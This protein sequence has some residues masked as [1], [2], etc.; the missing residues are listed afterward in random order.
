MTTDQSTPQRRPEGGPLSGVRVLEMGTLIAGPFATRVMADLGAEVIKIEPP[1]KGDP[2]REW[3]NLTDEGSLWFAVQARNKR[4]ITIDLRQPEGQELVRRLARE[5]D[6]LVENFRPG[7]LER[8]NLGWEVLHE[9]NP[10]LVMVRIS[11]FGQTGPYSQRPGFGNIAEAMG[12][13]RYITGFPDRPPLRVG[14][15]LADHVAALYAVVGAL[16]AL[17]SRQQSGQGQ[18][19]D[20]ALT[21][22]TFSFL[23]D[24]LPQYA[25][26]GTVQERE[27]NHLHFA[28]PSNAYETADGHW[29]AISGNG[30]SIFVRL[31]RAIG[32]EDLATDP[33]LSDNQ[34]RLRRVHELDEAIGA[35]TASHSA[36]EVQRALEQAEVPHGPIY[37]I[38]DIADDPQ[39]RA[40]NMILN[41]PHP[42]F[43][44]V[45]M[46]GILPVFSDTPGS[47]NWPG[48]DLGQ[49]TERVLHDVLGLDPAEVARLRGEGVV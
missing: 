39:Y 49:D 21:E 42:R 15:S 14:M 16:A 1:G 6:I 23:Q 43:G 28:A 33:G 13:L 36:A 38:K 31:M 9:L 40:R 35:W 34:G 41:V 11:G 3:G 7:A 8:W 22:S 12:G 18:V 44:E 45:V 30:D 2:L 47:V 29:M 17:E 10:R 48:P 26:F 20:V 24:A 19:V 32:R 46:P 5:S 27:G 25:R 37:S 4:S